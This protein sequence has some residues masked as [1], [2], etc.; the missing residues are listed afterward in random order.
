VLRDGRSATGQSVSKAESLEA[1]DPRFVTD[2]VPV[3]PSERIE[4]ASVS[5]DACDGSP[6]IG[7]GDRLERVTVAR[8]HTT[9]AYRRT[10]NGNRKNRPRR[11]MAGTAVLQC[12]RVQG[13]A[14]TMA[15]VWVVDRVCVSVFVVIT[16]TYYNVR[17]IIKV[18]TGAIAAGF[19]SIEHI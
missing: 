19:D 6:R 4:P 18:F 13:Q 1:D 11:S 2:A 15:T 8:R 16:S 10:K 9:A 12:Q 17:P 5:A 14:V 7:R 3:L